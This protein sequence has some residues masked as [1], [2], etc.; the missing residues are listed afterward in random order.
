MI[1]ANVSHLSPG[2]FFIFKGKLWLKSGSINNPKIT[3]EEFYVVGHSFP[4]SSFF[5]EEHYACINMLTGEL[6]SFSSEV[7]QPIAVDLTIHQGK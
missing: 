6:V 2:D 3:L 7:I 4:Y 1:K 5:R